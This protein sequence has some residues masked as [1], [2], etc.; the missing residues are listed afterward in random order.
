MGSIYRNENQTLK[1]MGRGHKLIQLSPSC[2]M[3]GK[4]N[5]CEKLLVTFY[6]SAIESILTYCFTVWFSLSTEAERER[7]QRL[8]ETEEKIIGCSLPSPNDL[9][10]SCC[11]TRAEAITR[12]S[13][14]PAHHLFDP[15]PSGRR[16]RSNK[17][18]AN[19]LKNSFFPP[20]ITARNTSRH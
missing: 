20:A 18:R 4:N 17:T 1:F 19:T 6:H 2:R 16:Y 11:L 13:T 10:S 7:L 3:I 15:L 14:H 12:D 5:I 8:V 9:Y